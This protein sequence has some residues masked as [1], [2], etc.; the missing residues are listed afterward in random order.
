MAKTHEELIESLK[1]A[2]IKKNRRN[3]FVLAIV[4]IVALVFIII[5]ALNIFKFE[6]RTNELVVIKDSL[7]SETNSIDKILSKQKTSKY[8]VY[9]FFERRFMQNEDS[10]RILFA[11]TLE[12]YYTYLNVP[13]ET[14]IKE[15]Y[16][17][18]KKFPKEKFNIDSSFTPVILE[19]K[20]IRCLIKGTY[21]RTGNDFK[22]LIQEIRM[23][24]DYKIYYA[25]SYF[26]LPDNL[27]D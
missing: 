1:Q 23:R 26:S 6:K 24:S 11:D 7:Q 2:E 22:E 15:D 4:L 19:D 25:R 13:K 20:N 17:Y 21:S 18:F 12:R 9:K 27:L 14:I 16:K 3:I 5:T 8:F 10:M